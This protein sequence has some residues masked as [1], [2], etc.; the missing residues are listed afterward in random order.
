MASRRLNPTKPS[1]PKD[2]GHYE[3][4]SDIPP[5]SLPPNGFVS[6]IPAYLLEGKSESEQFVLNELSKM[7][8]FVEFAGPLMVSTLNQ[9]RRTNGKVA[10]MWNIKEM[11]LGWKGLLGTIAGLAAFIAS[12]FEIWPYV[13]HFFI[14]S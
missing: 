7:S 2:D 14:H 9:C 4:H 5:V 3:D 8:S 6:K 10:I 11:A 12:V 1:M 13:K